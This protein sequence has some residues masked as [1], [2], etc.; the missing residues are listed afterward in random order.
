LQLYQ[1][2]GDAMAALREFKPVLDSAIPRLL[3]GFFEHMRRFNGRALRDEAVAR[4]AKDEQQRH[5]SQLFAGSLSSSYL[6]SAKAL[7]VEHAKAGI[8]ASWY[9]ASYNYLLSELTVL[10]AESLLKGGLFN[11]PDPRKL[12]RLL[13]ALSGIVLLDLD[14]TVAAFGADASSQD[15]DKLQSIARD[16][17]RT[18]GGAAESVGKAAEGLQ[19]NAKAMLMASERSSQKAMAVASAAEQASSN[20]QTVASA[21]EELSHS[22]AE[23]ANQVGRSSQVAAAAVRQAGNTSG[24]MKTLA[25]AANRIGEIVRLINDIASQTNLLALNATIEA[26]R[27]GEAGKGFAV[28]ASEVKSLA[29]QTARATE[30]IKNQVNEIQTVAG[31]AVDAIASIDAT[32][33]E[34]DEIGSAI[35]SSVEHQG[36]ATNEIA[37]NVYQAAAGTAEVSSNISGVTAAVDE[38]AQCAHEVIQSA[39]NL[40]RRSEDLRHQVATLLDQ[41]RKG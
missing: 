38:A 9:V 20:V 26:A 16:I 2:N 12:T 37:R 14:L 28:V 29:N 10:A 3:S 7:G 17:D 15:S 18:I 1:I 8:E 11:R 41:M 25:A 31:Q 4:R 33:R 13:N 5:W 24:T 36:A 27:A 22:I 6:A 34:I 19:S 23:I 39:A 21:A 35:A 32:I 30:D 40:E